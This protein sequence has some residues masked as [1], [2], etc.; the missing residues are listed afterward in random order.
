MTSRR[1]IYDKY[2]NSDIFNL[3][4]PQEKTERLRTRI[5]QSPLAITKDDLFNIEKKRP[6]EK[7]TKKGEKRSRIYSQIYGS[8]IFCRTQPNEVKKKEGIKRVITSYN[9]SKC[10]DGTKNN[11]EY[12]ENLI[13]YTKEHRV[14]KKEFNP[15]KYLKTE[16][17][18]ERY[19]KELYDPHGSTVLPERCFSSDG[20]DKQIY[21]EKKHSLNKKIAEYNDVG[22]DGKRKLIEENKSEKKI[23]V[24]KRNE[25]ADKNSGGYHYIDAKINPNNNSKINRQVNLQSNLFKDNNNLKQI[26]LN[27]EA[28]KKINERIEKEKEKKRRNK[29]YHIGNDYRRKDLALTDRNLWGAVHSKWEKTNLDWKNP[30]TEVM[31]G[32]GISADINRKYGPKG[33]TSFQ[34]KLNQLA[35]TK[36]KDTIN[37]E[38]KN[39]IINIEKPPSTERINSE[40]FKKVEKILN[41]IGNLKEDKKFKIKMNATT[42]LVNGEGEWDK[43]TK[44]LT[45]Y[46]TNPNWNAKNKNKKKN[47]LI[48]IGKEQKEKEKEIKSGHD[49][50]DY[51]LTYPSKGSFEKFDE[52]D[53]RLLFGNKGIHVYDVQK[54][55]FD[56][57]VYNTFR[58]KVRENEE[59]GNLGKKMDEVKKELEKKDLKIGINREKKRNLK[60]NTKNFVS[61][62]GAKLGI[63][64]ENIGYYNNAK[65]AKIPDNIRK[66][67]SFSKQFENINYGY[68]NNK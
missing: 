22:A 39:P 33:P 35:D 45:K 55:M 3:N 24:R 41:E 9:F 40:G 62:P 30:V 16:S 18:A 48:K 6:K 14:P 8:D 59:D 54:N 31:F 32:T 57:G 25:W 64:N 53:I 58:F 42:A 60:K 28:E 37:E 63:V 7:V 5:S 2:L 21:A 65:H 27:N 38:E 61:N 23:H 56:K 66:K 68:K 10:F 26:D 44:T 17:A 49:Y 36:N 67:K 43:K 20:K 34:R 50:G 11:E 13:K 15:D 4:C 46:Y 1:K 51:V 47:I 29:S 12:K 52:S 19:Y